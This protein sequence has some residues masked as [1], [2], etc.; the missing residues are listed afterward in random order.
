M[1]IIN[2]NGN[3]FGGDEPWLSEYL[4][5][6]KGVISILLAIIGVGVFLYIYLKLIPKRSR[7][8]LVISCFL[9]GLIGFFCW[10]KILGSVLLP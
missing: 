2:P 6:N 1:E 9:G 10:M 5:L 8:E 4:G 3:Y 7:F